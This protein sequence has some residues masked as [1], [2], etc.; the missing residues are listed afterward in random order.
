MVV[1]PSGTVTL[2]FTDIGGSTRLLEELGVD[3]YRLSTART[4]SELQFA[5]Q[6]GT[7]TVRS[8]PDA[9]ERHGGDA[10]RRDAKEARCT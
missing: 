8:A 3:A 6:V 10:N 2:V 4:R 7:L 5:R 9:P 1:Q